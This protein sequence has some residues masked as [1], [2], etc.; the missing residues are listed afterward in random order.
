VADTGASCHITNSDSGAVLAK[1]AIA[2]TRKLRPS[3]DASGNRM[4]IKA[5]IN[6][7]AE[8]LHSKTK[9]KMNMI[10][11]NCRFVGSKFNLCSLIKMTNSGWKVAG[12]TTGIYLRKDKTTIHFSIP[13]QTPEGQILAIQMERTAS[14]GQ[15]VSL[16]SPPAT[17][18]EMSTE[19][20]HY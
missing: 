6:I 12:D 19:R 1:D 13:I 18:R 20:A 9:Q 8:V 5:L 4:K 17:A 15:E 3:L 7:T 14:N 2:K 16:A 11:V 10:M